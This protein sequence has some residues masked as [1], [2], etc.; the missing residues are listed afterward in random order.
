MEQSRR[1]TKSV[2][3]RWSQFGISA[4]VEYGTF[5]NRITLSHMNS[6]LGSDLVHVIMLVNNY[7]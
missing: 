7:T 4:Y 2:Q 5:K 1:Q 3:P 6:L